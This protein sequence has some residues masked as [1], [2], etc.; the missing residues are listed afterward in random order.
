[1]VSSDLCIVTRLLVTKMAVV[2]AKACGVA[3]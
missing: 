2:L 3:L 1:M